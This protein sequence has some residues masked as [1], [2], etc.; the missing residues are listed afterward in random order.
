M[1]RDRIMTLAIDQSPKLQ[2]QFAVDVL[3]DHFGHEGSP[4]NRPYVSSVPIVL[5]GPEY[6]P[7]GFDGNQSP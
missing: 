2:A 1:L 3:L 4:V 7:S 5:F 6:I